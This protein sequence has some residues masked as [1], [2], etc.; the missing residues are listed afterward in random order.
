MG[1]TYTVKL[2]GVPPDR[3]TTAELRKTVEARLQE[4]NRQMSHHLP[5]SELSRFNQSSSTE[6]FSVST[7]LAHVVRCAL[8]WAR[9]SNGAFDPTIAPLVNLWGFGPRAPKSRVPTDAEI[10][11]AMRRCG[12]Q[13]LRVTSAAQLQ[14]TVPELQ[15]NLGAIGKGFA[16]DEIARLLRTRGYTN[17]FV[18]VSGEIVTLGRNQDGRPWRIGIEYP[19]YGP[20]RSQRLIAIIE[21]SGR[22]IATSGGT[23]QF[24]RDSEGRIYPHVL[25]PRTG[26]PVQHRLASVT[27]V[28]PDAISADA[29]A[30]ILFVLGVKEGLRWLQSRPQLA[31][32]FIVP[33]DADRFEL[34]PSDGFPP[35]R[36]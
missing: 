23:H 31:A 15:L 8:Q 11:A 26:R 16:A 25:D 17:L 2:A 5:H 32:L 33:S 34:V 22:A 12:H 27:V 36:R 3:A 9:E 10:A 18:S 14:K 29:A 30:T 21:L 20:R 1:T 24:F 35:F 6:P 7:E 28:A 13:H 19:E 4:L